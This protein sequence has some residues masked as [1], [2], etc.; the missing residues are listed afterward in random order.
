MSASLRDNDEDSPYG[1]RRAR[2]TQYNFSGKFHPDLQRI[3]N[4]QRARLLAV[5][6][7]LKCRNVQ[8]RF[9]LDGLAAQ[10]IPQGS[11]GNTFNEHH[12][13]FF[14]TNS[15]VE[16]V[17]WPHSQCPQTMNSPHMLLTRKLC[18]IIVITLYIEGKTEKPWGQHLLQIVLST[19][20]V[21]TREKRWKRIIRPWKYKKHM[22]EALRLQVPGQSGKHSQRAQTRQCHPAPWKL[23]P[24]PSVCYLHALTKAQGKWTWSLPKNLAKA[25]DNYLAKEGYL[26]DIFSN[27]PSGTINPVYLP[28]TTPEEYKERV[29][30]K[31]TVCLNSCPISCYFKGTSH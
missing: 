6:V 27:K 1:W 29:I 19:V 13:T 31:N 5:H 23:N 11:G 24:C 16:D 21:K 14:T 9:L 10:T 26:E 22:S 17:V 8:F 18:W 2:K 4:T 12:S 15:S 25:L 20:W 7:N 30:Q 3:G 28:Q